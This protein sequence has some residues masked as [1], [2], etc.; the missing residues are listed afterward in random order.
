MLYKI[1]LDL[2]DAKKNNIMTL[3]FSAKIVV[4]LEENNL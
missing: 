4:K 1:Y 3:H 2:K